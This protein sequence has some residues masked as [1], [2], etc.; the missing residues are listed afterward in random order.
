MNKYKR[1]SRTAMRIGANRADY[2]KQTVHEI[3]DAGFVCHIGFVLD[4]QAH[5]IPTSYARDGERILI[6]G[7]R[8][9]RMLKSL[10]DGVPMT[11]TVTHTD[12][13]VLGRSAFHHSANFRSVCVFGTAR[14]VDG[15][16][17]KLAAVRTLT[18]FIVPGRWESL[19]PVSQEELDKTTVIEIVIE[20]AVAKVRNGPPV[21]DEADYALP[22]WAGVLPFE[23]CCAPAVADDRNLP[24]AAMPEHVERYRRKNTILPLKS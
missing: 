11:I 7:S 8:L 5:V 19:R 23:T 14:K 12:G 22:I 24:E 18:D 20:D 2:D 17:D 1:T 9:S 4:G 3:L 6:H 21:D 16:A 10:S 13:L 15:N